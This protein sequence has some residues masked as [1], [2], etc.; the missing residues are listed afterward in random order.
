MVEGVLRH[1]LVWLP[2]E[3]GHSFYYLY[4]RGY[5]FVP[6]C[7]FVCEKDYANVARPI[8]IKLTREVAHG[9]RNS[10]MH[11]GVYPGNLVTSA[12]A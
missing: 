4:H 2:V 7:L 12:P 8:F 5:V 6:A 10:L 9:Q 11:F 1:E 3:L